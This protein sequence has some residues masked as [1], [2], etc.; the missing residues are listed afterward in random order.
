M[1]VSIRMLAL[2]LSTALVACQPQETSSLSSQP[3]VDPT[4]PTGDTCIA[5]YVR[6]D[7][8]LA[9]D[10]AHINPPVRCT[11]R[12]ID[13]S[14]RPA[15]GLRAAG[16]V[17]P[18]YARV[19]STPSRYAPR[20]VAQLFRYNQP[21]G[22][23][24]KLEFKSLQGVHADLREVHRL[25]VPSTTTI[26]GFSI[27]LMSFYFSEPDTP[28]KMVCVAGINRTTEAAM[29]IVCRS[30]DESAE[31]DLPAFAGRI[32]RDDLAAVRF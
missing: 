18:A 22:T 31:A 13:E 21:S 16:K 14:G 26:D 27:E 7:T 23:G 19:Y 11:N 10:L 9:S 30:F 6:Q 3:P 4:G 24:T 12:I 17:N 2:G 8:N 5:T 28:L 1:P 20:L 32:A 15:H 29:G 25:A